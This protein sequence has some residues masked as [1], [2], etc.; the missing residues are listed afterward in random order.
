[1]K[2]ITLLQPIT[3]ASGSVNLSKEQA[4]C[5]LHNLIDKGDGVYEIKRPIGFKA[6]EVFEYDGVIPKSHYDAVDGMIEQEQ[7]LVDETDAKSIETLHWKQLKKR[8]EDAG[9]EYVN[10]KDAVEFL[11]GL[12]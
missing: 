12:E 1:M 2:E 6:G 11:K 4:A 5:R 7:N 8:V 9:G 3:L 10:T